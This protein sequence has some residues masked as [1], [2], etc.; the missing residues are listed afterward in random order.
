MFIYQWLSCARHCIKSCT[1]VSCWTI[2]F[3]VQ[4]LGW[5]AIKLRF[6]SR[7]ISTKI[8]EGSWTQ[9]F[10]P[11]WAVPQKSLLSRPPAATSHPCDHPPSEFCPPHECCLLQGC[12]QHAA[13][14][15]VFLLFFLCYY[16]I[17]LKTFYLLETGKGRQAKWAK[18]H[19]Y[20]GAGRLQRML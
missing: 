9:C 4:N 19:V 16:Q 5:F 8:Y 13:L 6:Q 2:I 14:T 17:S 10:P 1:H 18:A 20:C 12:D 3:I 11:K 7:P 15:L